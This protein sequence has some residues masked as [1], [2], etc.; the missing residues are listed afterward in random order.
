MEKIESSDIQLMK[1]SSLDMRGRTFV[2]GGNFYRGIYAGYE[3]SIKKLF[4]CGLIEELN[5]ARL[6]PQT[7]I[8]NYYSDEFPLIIKHEFIEP[9]LYIHEWTYHMLCDAALMIEKLIKVLHKYGYGLW[10]C[11]TENILFCG[12]EPVYCDLGSFFLMEE[13]AQNHRG[14]PFE[15]FKTYYI[16]IAKMLRNNGSLA[17]SFLN[18][19]ENIE[20]EDA[21]IFC[22]GL[23]R[24]ILPFEN[25]FWRGYH[26]F[27]K[28]TSIFEKILFSHYSHKVRVYNKRLVRKARWS[29]YQGLNDQLL[30]SYDARKTGF[31]RFERVLDVIKSLEV[32]TIYE[33][34][35]NAGLLSILC[36]KK[37]SNIVRY[38]SC[39]YDDYSVDTLYQFI[40]SK[41]HE[42]EY[43][44][45]IIPLIGS[46]WDSINLKNR[47]SADRLRSDLVIGLAISHHLLLAQGMNID[48]MFESFAS[49][50]NR[51]IIIEFMPLGLWSG[52][53]YP[54]VPGWYT[55]DWFL[56]HMKKKF[57]VMSVEQTEENRIM[58][59]GKLL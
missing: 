3:D 41:K 11:H 10:D 59:V 2:Y 52:G 42:Q 14:I 50:T 1:S 23:Q 32:S 5:N 56:E 8:S 22:R 33:W 43:L 30:A 9:C 6:I 39:D 35:A 4:D 19:Y 46:F 37:Y 27:V 34:G 36:C 44:N 29:N 7:C 45:K 15:Q 12:I 13:L 24:R 31:L 21:E 55:I 51:Y 47:N 40:R 57:E 18:N 20:L 58:I 17:R 54:G 28:N 48:V 38:V 16:E 53:D 49:Y 25:Y 26:K